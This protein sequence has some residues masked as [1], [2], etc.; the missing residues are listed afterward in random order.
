MNPC[1]VISLKEGGCTTPRGFQHLCRAGEGQ[2]EVQ[3]SMRMAGAERA[4]PDLSSPLGIQHR[5]QH[6]PSQN[7]HGRN[8]F[9]SPSKSLRLWCPCQFRS[10]GR[11]RRMTEVQHSQG[12]FTPGQL[13]Q[14]RDVPA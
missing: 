8:F 13:E 5:V 12:T 6:I 2:R 10:V 11:K 3:H 4:A 7:G 1:R 9:P 14:L